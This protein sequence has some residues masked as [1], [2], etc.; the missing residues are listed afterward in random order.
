M[1][2]PVY[3]Q[4]DYDKWGQPGSDIPGSVL[5]RAY[6]ACCGSPIRV[7]CFDEHKSEYCGDCQGRRP[8][9]GGGGGGSHLDSP[10]GYQENA[11]RQMEGD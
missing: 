4:P 3:T 2:K 9:I 10:T 1:M 11:I 6:C 8:P 5:V 7:A